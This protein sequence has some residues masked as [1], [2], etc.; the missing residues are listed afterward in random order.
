[1]HR[2]QPCGAKPKPNILISPTSGWDISSPQIGLSGQSA[3]D[4]LVVAGPATLTAGVPRDPAY[5]STDGVLHAC[6]AW[7]LG[8]QLPAQNGQ[9]QG[10]FGQDILVEL[11][12]VTGPA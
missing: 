11:P 8:V 4:G 6:G 2:A 9:G 1:M 7:R 5:P 3:D 10:S 12:R